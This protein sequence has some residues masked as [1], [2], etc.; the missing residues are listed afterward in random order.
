MGSC[1]DH[2]DHKH[3]HVCNKHTCCDGRLHGR[4]WQPTALCPKRGWAGGACSERRLGR[5]LRVEG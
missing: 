3:C 2:H 5:G 4:R 1:R